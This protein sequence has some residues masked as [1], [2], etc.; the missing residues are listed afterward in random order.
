MATASS[1]GWPHS[2]FLIVLL[3][4]LRFLNQLTLKTSGFT[5]EYLC[6]THKT[7]QTNMVRL[8]ISVEDV[9]RREWAT[10]KSIYWKPKNLL[11]LTQCCLKWT[12]LWAG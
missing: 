7:V 1:S 8:L 2:I 9:N 5:E 3:L 4:I 12:E 10:V 11:L 6:N